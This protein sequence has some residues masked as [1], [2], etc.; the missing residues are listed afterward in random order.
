MKG[1]AHPTR[2][3]GTH[4][5]PKL[6]SIELGS[7][8]SCKWTLG[9]FPISQ[10]QRGAAGHP[11][12]LGCSSS[13]FPEPAGPGSVPA[14]GWFHR[15]GSTREGILRG[16]QHPAMPRL[17]KGFQDSA[18][19]QTRAHGHTFGNAGNAVQAPRSPTPPQPLTSFSPSQPAEP[20]SP[21]SPQ[22][23][24]SVHPSFCP[25]PCV[26][27]CV[28]VSQGWAP[29]LSPQDPGAPGAEGC[30]SFSLAGIQLLSL[31]FPFSFSPGI[32]PL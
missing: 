18:S 10:H 6:H 11:Q 20:P 1:K 12:P 23:F 31:V 32:R 21:V 8:Q 25:R 22:L 30:F 16:L 3:H 9:A 28:S 17:T 13:G 15:K 7:T 2:C 14:A 29:R 24:P 26:C 19:E 5:F 4:S 27:V